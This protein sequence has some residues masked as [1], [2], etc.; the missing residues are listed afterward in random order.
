[1]QT[2]FGDSDLPAAPGS[3]AQLAIARVAVE[4]AVDRELDYLIPPKLASEVSVGQRVKV[5]LGRGNHHCYAYVI[6]L[7]G[8]SDVPISRL[9]PITAIDDARTLLTPALLDLARWMCRYYVTP[10]GT[11]LESVIPSAVKNRTGIGQIT[12]VQ[13]ALTHAQMQELLG[14]SKRG[15]T[16]AILGALLNLSENES[17]ELVRL[18]TAAGVK[19]PTLRRLAGKG[20]LKMTRQ[21]DYGLPPQVEGQ[22]FTPEPPLPLNAQQQP[23]LNAISAQITAGRFAISLL[24]GITGS[25]KTEI[26]LH[27]IRQVVD[28][29]KQAI[30]LVPEI[31][32]TPQTAQRFLRRFGKVAILHSGLSAT[33]RHAQWRSIAAGRACVVVG[34]RSA[35]FAPLPNLGLIV[36]DEEH[37]SSYKQESAP[38]YHARD[39]AIKRAQMQNIPIVLGSAT[40]SLEMY[41]RIRAA[42]VEAQASGT[43]G[44]A[45]LV[46]SQRATPQQLPKVE[47]IDMKMANI[48]RPG[49]HLLSPRLEQAMKNTFAAGQ[50]AILLLNRRGYAS[51]IRCNACK[52]AVQCKYCSVAMVYHRS[53]DAHMHSGR[54]DLAVGTGSM[55]C[56]YCLAVNP[57][58]T[59]CPQCGTKLSLFGLGTQRVEEELQKKMPGV[60]FARVDS[61][62]MHQ[63]S[64]YESVLNAFGAGKI[65]LLMGTQ[66]IAKGLDFPNVTLVGVI[67]GDTALALPD[68][69]AAERTF[70]LLTQ[71]SGRAGRGQKAGIVILQSY[72]PDD[73]TIRD[74]ISQNYNAFALRELGHRKSAQLPPY[75]RMVRIV[76]RET[77]EKKLEQLADHIYTQLKAAAPGIPDLHLQEPIECAISRI[78]G[79]HRKQIIMHSPTTASLQQVLAV[80]RKEGDLMQGDRIAIDVDPV[81]LL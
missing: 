38:R 79:H 15:K 50:Q 26:Y 25:G 65:Q 49:I 13:A 28:A 37:E 44:H 14:K 27:A 19:I 43:P 35:I 69:R 55:H 17:I 81:S 8:H 3:T 36:I 58:P 39:V 6:G 1:V 70:Q 7:P 73:L 80:L 16:S 46:L 32:L 51:Y 76:L 31:A 41:H 75:T 23:A 66:M 48:H 42:A 18:A 5:P 2:L 21:V 52:E 20:I 30:V 63:T 61:D 53:K 54:T 12:M 11:V 59:S 71:V 78:A 74:A 56:H 10:L 22:Q 29:G 33:E 24:H 68:F 47:L 60:T 34:A 9:K 57:L 77:D 72:L 40:P 64:D 4:H 45:Y 67:S 62:T